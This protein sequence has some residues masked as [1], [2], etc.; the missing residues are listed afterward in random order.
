MLKKIYRAAQIVT[1]HGFPHLLGQILIRLSSKAYDLKYVDNICFND[2]RLMLQKFMSAEKDI[3]DIS[4]TAFNYWGSGPYL[5]I[6]PLQIPSEIE[7]L[8]VRVEEIKPRSMVEIGTAN[9]GSLYFFSRY[10][11][12]CRQIIS[13]NLPLRYS[14]LKDKFFRLYDETKVF[15]FLRGPSYSFE[16]INGVSNILNGSKVDFLFIDGDH[17]Y[18]GVKKDFYEYKNFVSNNGIIAFHDISNRHP[19]IGVGKF[20]NEIKHTYCSEEI[21]DSINQVWGGVGIIVLE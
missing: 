17:S 13:I 6:R 5:S 3:Y 21:I 15:H 9:G 18:D 8:T 11:K 2:S 16:I 7:K 4:G 10:F 14:E 19:S 20:W 1:K 12:T